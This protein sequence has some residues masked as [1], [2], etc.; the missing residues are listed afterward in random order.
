MSYY[1]NPYAGNRFRIIGLQ[2]AYF[3]TFSFLFVCPRMFYRLSHPLGYGQDVIMCVRHILARRSLIRLRQRVIVIG[4]LVCYT[5]CPAGL[6]SNIC[7]YCDVF[8]GLVV[9]SGVRT[10][11]NLANPY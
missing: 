8:E 7:A 9:G 4:A 10:K 3:A 1:E 6:V 5:A 11:F 2:L